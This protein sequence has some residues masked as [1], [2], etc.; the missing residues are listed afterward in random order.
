MQHSLIKALRRPV[1]KN[2]C[3][4]GFPSGSVVKNLPANVGDTIQSLLWEVATSQGATKPMPHLLSLCSR[5]QEPQLRS[6]RATACE[7]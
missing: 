1:I 7:A 2:N 4:R 3:F 5:A 6:P